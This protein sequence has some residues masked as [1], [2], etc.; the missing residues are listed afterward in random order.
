MSMALARL[1]EWFV[2]SERNKAVE[3]FL[4]LF[5]CNSFV[6]VFLPLVRGCQKKMVANW[7]ILMTM[8]LD[9]FIFSMD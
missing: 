6:L 9:L 4:F 1:Y 5:I 2:F 8:P 3:A 7:V